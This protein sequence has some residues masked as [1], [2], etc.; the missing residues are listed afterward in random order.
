M[1]VAVVRIQGVEVA[2]VDDVELAKVIQ[3]EIAAIEI[4]VGPGLDD[5]P[6]AGRVEGKADKGVILIVKAVGQCALDAGLPTEIL[7]HKREVEAAQAIVGHGQ[8]LGDR[9]APHD[10]L[11]YG[12]GLGGDAGRVE[13]EFKVELGGPAGRHVDRR[14][15]GQVTDCRSCHGVGA[16]G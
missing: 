4:L 3:E 6:V 15:L 10:R 7:L 8:A 13:N 9:H 12:R 14:C 11:L 1:I 5:I 16:G 2:A